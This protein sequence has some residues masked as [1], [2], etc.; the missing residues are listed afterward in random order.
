MKKMHQ[1]ISQLSCLGPAS[2][3]MQS[4]IGMATREDLL[5]SGPDHR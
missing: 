1:R 4:A 5:E 2:G 3:N